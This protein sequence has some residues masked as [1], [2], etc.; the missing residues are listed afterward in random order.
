VITCRLMQLFGTWIRRLW[1]L[2]CGN[3]S[4]T[5]RFQVD[6]VATF[7]LETVKE[8]LLVTGRFELVQMVDPCIWLDRLFYLN[9]EI[10]A[11]TMPYCNIVSIEPKKLGV[12]F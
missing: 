5:Y 11:S 9:I 1:K 8:T 7:L 10:K 4:L 2:P 3:E 6:V 12:N